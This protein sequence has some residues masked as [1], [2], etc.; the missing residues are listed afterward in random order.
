MGALSKKKAKQK[1]EI[2][3]ILARVDRLPILDFRSEDEILGYDE[4]GLP[5]STAPDTSITPAQDAPDS[6]KIS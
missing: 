4:N 1:A 5:A 6:Q 2:D 3:K